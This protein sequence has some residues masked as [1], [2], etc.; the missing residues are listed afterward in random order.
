MAP[1]L[2]GF[3]LT[4]KTGIRTARSMA[5]A[6]TAAKLSALGSDRHWVAYKETGTGHGHGSKVSNPT[7]DF[8][9]E[10][11]PAAQSTEAS[12]APSTLPASAELVGLIV[13]SDPRLVWTRPGSHFGVR[14]AGVGQSALLGGRQKPSPHH[15]GQ[16]GESA[17]ISVKISHLE[18][19][20]ITSIKHRKSSSN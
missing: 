11:P 6:V 12:S 18:D 9:L 15:C 1:A 17:S 10:G 19:R 3:V 4:L 16:E 13:G 2:V 14:I 8:D 5:S 20:Q 7:V